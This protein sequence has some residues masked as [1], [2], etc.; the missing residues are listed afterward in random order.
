LTIINFLKEINTEFLQRKVSLV[1]M[2]VKKL[3]KD[4]PDNCNHLL[5]AVF[6]YASIGIIVSDFQGNIILANVY[7]QKKF[8]YS[9]K[10]MENL[11]VEKLIPQRFLKDHLSHWKKY[12]Q[13]PHDRPMGMGEGLFALRKDGTECPVEINLGHYSKNGSG[14]IIAVI[15]DISLQKQNETEIKRLNE[16]LEDQ[17][18]QR[19]RQL[20]EAVIK[21]QLSKEDLIHSL[22]KEKDL[23]ELKSRFVT[24]ASHEFRTPLSTV[25]SSAYLLE[26]Y[27]TTDEQPRRKKHIERIISSVNTLTDI[28][29]DFLSVGKIEEGKIAIKMIPFNIRD[30]IL[31]V[32]NEMKNV[33]KEGQEVSYRHIGEEIIEL[34]PSLMKHILMNLLSNAIK[35]SPENSPIDINSEIAN[36]ELQLSIKDKGIG[37]PKDDIGNLY[38]RFHRGAN[39]TYIQGT[40][41]GLH[42]VAKYTEL[43]KGKIECRSELEKGTEFIITFK[44]K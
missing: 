27:I 19:T 29:N 6:N 16:I 33:R 42:I 24:M 23:N 8:G 40:G 38:D 11:K 2:Q 13:Q 12:A 41:L 30:L 4:V 14:Y 39:V 7:A 20:K 34:D 9:S 25:L 15:S 26:K 5:E 31:N 32:I 17:V 1:F 18:E 36:G 22:Q 10:E 28:L 44:K 37:I 21:L 3:C 43:L 35:F